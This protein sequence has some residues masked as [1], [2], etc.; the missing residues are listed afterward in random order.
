[1][2]KHEGAKYKI[3]AS[4]SEEQAEQLFLQ[5]YDDQSIDKLE[6]LKVIQAWSR[7]DEDN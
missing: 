2:V 1:V 5:F 6:F 7:R 3:G 4:P